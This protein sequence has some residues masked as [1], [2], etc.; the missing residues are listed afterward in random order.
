MLN[1]PLYGVMVSVGYADYADISLTHNRSQLDRC[2]LV[3][4]PDDKESQR[5][6]GKHACDL[7]IT[8]D[9]RRPRS[10]QPKDEVKFN[11]GALVERGL[12]QLPNDGYRVHF[13]S[14]IIF[15]NN[16]RRRLGIRV[17]DKTCIYGVDRLNVLGEAKYL[18]LLNAGIF[19][20]GFEHHHFLT[21]PVRG[22]EVGGRLIFDDQGWLPI[23]YFQLWHASVEMSGVYR[24]RTYPTGSNTAAHDD[25]QFALK[26]D[27]D[28]RVL[29]PDFYVFHLL[30]D[31]CKY[32]ANWNGRKTIPFNPFGAVSGDM[33]GRV[34]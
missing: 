16:M 29:I 28:K 6:A 12:Q 18:E 9:A 11:K 24:T 27:V 5:V 34:S 31:D 7:V 1:E 17:K 14:D 2:V 8:D 15:P 30:T 23:G 22:C 10:G 13:D 33:K 19:T 21:Y 4:S 3:T 26:W 32:G 25:V 20:R